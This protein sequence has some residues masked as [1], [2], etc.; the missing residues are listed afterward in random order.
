[1]AAKSRTRRTVS[2]KIAAI[3]RHNGPDDPPLESLKLARAALPIGEIG[4]VGPPAPPPPPPLPRARADG[5]VRLPR[6]MGRRAWAALG[7]LDGVAGGGDYAGDA[8]AMAVDGCRARGSPDGEIG[9]ALGIPRQAVWKRF[10]RQPKVD[11]GPP[12]S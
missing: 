9:A 6:G 12:E 8:L 2:G 7:A 5:G 4:P 10:P 11:A 3:E 1:M